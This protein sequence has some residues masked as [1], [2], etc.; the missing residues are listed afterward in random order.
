[1]DLLLIQIKCVNVRK[2]QEIYRGG[3][4]LAW[5]YFG[6]RAIFLSILRLKTLQ[7]LLGTMNQQ[8]KN[9]DAFLSKVKAECGPNLVRA[10]RHYLQH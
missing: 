10:M 1:M 9:R 8:S 3:D 6:K 2:T 4:Q 7:L 5:I